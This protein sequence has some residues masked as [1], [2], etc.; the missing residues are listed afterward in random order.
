M[1]Q[2]VT[3]LS[4]SGFFGCAEEVY[5]EEEEDKDGV[6]TLAGMFTSNHEIPLLPPA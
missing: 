4:T 6:T 5:G 2:I 1:K 3:K